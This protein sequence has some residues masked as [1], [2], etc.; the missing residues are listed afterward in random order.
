MNVAGIALGPLQTNVYLVWDN[1]EEAVLIDP[2]GEPEKL[3]AWISG[4]AV[5]PRAILLTHAHFDHVGAVAAAARE[6]AAPVYLHPLAL[7]VY[8]RAVEAAR[9]WGF[10]IEPPPAADPL[11]LTEGGFVVGPGF[12]VLH[13][14][15]HCPGHVAFYNRAAA[16]AFAGDVLFAGGVGRW[17]IPSAN[18]EQLQATIRKLFGLPAETTIYPGHGPA[19]TLAAERSG[20]RYVR[21]W[22]EASS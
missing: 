16:A 14:P 3:R 10:R 7:P 1:E 19:T 22:L 6:Y 13:L 21:S 8:R 17:D 9:N 15:G 11:P 20:N 12:T 2:G 5:R 4:L 18:K